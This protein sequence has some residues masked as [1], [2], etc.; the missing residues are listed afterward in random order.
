[1]GTPADFSRKGHSARGI[2][3]KYCETCRIWRNQ[4]A[5]HCLDC[6][7]CMELWD[8]HCGV[9]GLCIA[10]K[11]RRWFVLMLLSAAASLAHLVAGSFVHLKALGCP[12][13][14]NA[15]CW[16]APDTYFLIASIVPCGYFGLMILLF[17]LYHTAL[18]AAD[19][20]QRDWLGYSGAA[21][22]PCSATGMPCRCARGALRSP[23]RLARATADAFCGRGGMTPYWEAAAASESD[24]SSS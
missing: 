16:S 23:S 15:P 24:S 20:T 14:E 10:R 12:R 8:H 3:F 9:V 2:F 5:S 7:Y 22:E 21:Y 4:R 6:G 18:A 13:R 17:G 19:V 1:M 11:N